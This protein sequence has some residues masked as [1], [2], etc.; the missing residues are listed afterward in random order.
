MR[1]ALILAALA[2]AVPASGQQSPIAASRFGI[3][4]DGVEIASFTELAG[5]SSSVHPVEAPG[6]NGKPKRFHVEGLV[7]L[8]R[9]MTTSLDMWAWHEAARFDRPRHLKDMVLLVYDVNGATVAR[10]TLTDA[11]PKKIENGS[12][13]TGSSEVLM[14]TVTLVCERIE[15][16]AP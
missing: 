12:L 2:V 4:I 14:E 16:V 9:P 5:I 11:W 8:R 15:R 10:Y 3:S 6:S 1:I 13:A 7:T